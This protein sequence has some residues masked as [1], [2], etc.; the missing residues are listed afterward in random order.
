[1][2]EK[3]SPSSNIYLFFGEDTF[4]MRRKIDH[5]KSE[6]AKKYSASS[7]AIVESQNIAEMDLIKKLRDELAPSLFSTKKLLIIKDCLPRKATQTEL[8]DFLLAFVL[9][10]PKDYFVIF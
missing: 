4:S 10:I 6:F 7:I 5:W 2:T 9:L 1:M 3:I 8:V